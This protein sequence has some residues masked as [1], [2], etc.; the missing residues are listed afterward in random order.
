MLVLGLAGALAGAVG[1]HSSTGQRQTLNVLFVLPA[2]FREV[3]YTKALEDTVSNSSAD[4]GQGT[5]EH[6]G[7]L[8]GGFRQPLEGSAPP[9]LAMGCWRS[10]CASVPT[11]RRQEAR[12]SPELR[13]Q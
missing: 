3:L 10:A 6:W 9:V 7:G 4:T 1:L 11:G 2:D 13:G 5:R 12:G 8:G